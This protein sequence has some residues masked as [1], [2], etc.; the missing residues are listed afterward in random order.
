MV[1]FGF[2]P[3]VLCIISSLSEILVYFSFEAQERPSMLTVFCHY[4]VC[5]Y[6]VRT[7]LPRCFDAYGAFVLHLVP[8]YSFPNLSDLFFI[9]I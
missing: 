9:F 4:M 2:A 8:V 1:I 3:C 6:Y 7:L 5:M